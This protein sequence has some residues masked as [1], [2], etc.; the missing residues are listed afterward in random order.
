MQ[1]SQRGAHIADR[2]HHVGADDE[3]ER[4]RFQFLLDA[5][6]FE[7]EN[8]EFHF[9]KRRQLLRCAGEKSSRHIAEDVGMQ[10]TLEQR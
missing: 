10:T 9:R 4:R 7:I 1:I 5:R 6:F 3:V 8:L 2:V